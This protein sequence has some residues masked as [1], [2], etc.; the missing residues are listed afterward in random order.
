MLEGPRSRVTQ[1]KA[2]QV[3][4]LTM[5][6]GQTII[7]AGQEVNQTVSLKVE[8]DEQGRLAIVLRSLGIPEADLKALFVALD[9]EADLGEENE[10]GPKV[11]VG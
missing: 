4:Y 10:F 8:Q 1:E 9:E 11:M 2:N 3:S 5:S 7:A 6:G